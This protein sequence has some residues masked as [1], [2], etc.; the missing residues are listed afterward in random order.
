MSGRIKIGFVDFAVF[1]FRF[2]CVCCVL[3]RSFLVRWRPCSW[4]RARIGLPLCSAAKQLTLNQRVPGSSPGAPTKL[5][6]HLQYYGSERLSHL[7]A[8]LGVF[9][10]SSVR[11]LK[12]WP[13]GCALPQRLAR[14]QASWS[15]LSGR[16]LGDRERLHLE[17]VHIPNSFLYPSVHL[18]ELLDR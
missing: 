14:L 9:C 6:K 11:P 15:A 1:S 7:G 5:I 2:D 18:A 8:H 17:S 4:R 10:S 12:G 16:S 3:M 13:D